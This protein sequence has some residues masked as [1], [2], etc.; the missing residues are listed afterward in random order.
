MLYSRTSIEFIAVHV[1]IHR[2]RR[3]YIADVP[4]IPFFW[5]VAFG[6]SATIQGSPVQLLRLGLE[7]CFSEF[8][9]LIQFFLHSM[10]GDF[11]PC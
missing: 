2:V 9:S 1:V 6:L 3:Q 4:A 5:H 11:A 8:I 10:D 7:T